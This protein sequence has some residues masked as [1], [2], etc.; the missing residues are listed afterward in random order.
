MHVFSHSIYIILDRL[1]QWAKAN[2][3]RFNKAKCRVLHLGHNNPVQRHSL[4]KSGWKAAQRKRTWGCWLT[5][6]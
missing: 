2:C 6:G 1:D 3:M 4:G 5:A